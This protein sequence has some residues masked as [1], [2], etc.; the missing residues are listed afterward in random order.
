MLGKY[1]III[2]AGTSKHMQVCGHATQEQTWSVEEANFVPALK[3]VQFFLTELLK[4]VQ[5]L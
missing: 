1:Y 3:D 5:T 4:Y 2:R